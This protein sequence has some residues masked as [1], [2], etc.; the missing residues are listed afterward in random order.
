MKIQI[1]NND[2]Y[3]FHFL[4]RFRVATAETIAVVLNQSIRSTQRRLQQLH[5]S[6]HLQRAR[7]GIGQP[8]IY[9]VTTKSILDYVDKITYKYQ[10]AK[11]SYAHELLV[12]QVASYIL[13]DNDDVDLFDIETDR[14]QYIK[15]KRERLKKDQKPQ[16][17]KKFIISDIFI[18][19]YSCAIEVELSSKPRKTIENKLIYMSRFC[20]NQIWIM[21]NGFKTLKKTCEDF[22]KAIDDRGLKYMENDDMIIVKE[23]ER[24][25]KSNWK[26]VFN[27]YNMKDRLF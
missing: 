14:T 22:E 21:P 8:Y 12:S 1:R 23:S 19:K 11:L 10:I 5:K 2:I 17:M 20:K 6:G 9:T 7:T 18:E 4:Y 15:I 26:L 25:P 13:R 16:E 3:V 27:S 24:V